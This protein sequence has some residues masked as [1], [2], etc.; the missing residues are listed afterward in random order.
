[1]IE[2]TSHMTSTSTSTKETL[3]LEKPVPQPSLPSKV[4]ESKVEE[5]KECPWKF[6]GMSSFRHLCPHIKEQQTSQTS[7]PPPPSD[8][9]T[10]THKTTPITSTV[11]TTSTSNKTNPA[12]SSTSTSSWV[13]GSWQWVKSCIIKPPTNCEGV[14]VRSNLSKKDYMQILGSSYLLSGNEKVDIEHLVGKTIC[15]YFSASWCPPC[16]RCV[17]IYTYTIHILYILLILDLIV[18]DKHYL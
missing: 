13:G 5:P 9:P 15:L 17:Y 16:R 2:K 14:E 4:E 3:S 10:D 12:S 7:P 8:T 18:C 11:S 1:M 6:K